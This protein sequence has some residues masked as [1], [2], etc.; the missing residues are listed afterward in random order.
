MLGL[1]ST[2]STPLRRTRRRGARTMEPSMTTILLM[3]ALAGATDSATEDGAAGGKTG[4]VTI[5]PQY[6]AG[7]FHRWLWGNDY[8][9]LWTASID[10]PVLD[11]QTFAGG[12]KPV[13]RVGGQQTKGLAMK[14]ADG[15][16]YTFRGHRQGP[17]RDP[18]R[19]PAG[20]LGAQRRPGPDGRPAPRVPVRRG[21]AHGGRRDPSHG[22]APD[23]D[24]R[25][26]RARRVPQGVR[27]A[28]W[29]RCT[30]S[31]GRSPTRTPAFRAPPRS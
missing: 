22:A 11:L 26:S 2:I 3:L 21:R 8:R 28:W 1:W 14:G 25:R 17:D 31:R 10:V 18:A 30:S 27:R 9:D 23:G 4:Q 16:D 24:A 19:G 13:R 5:A 12:L 20:H 29:A 6:Q 7:G 15:R